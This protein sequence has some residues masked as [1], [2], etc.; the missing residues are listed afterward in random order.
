MG[1][2]PCVTPTDPEGQPG[3][4]SWIGCWWLGYVIA[5]CLVVSACLPMFFLFPKHIIPP[6]ERV[7]SSGVHTH[8]KDKDKE[9]ISLKD[10]IK[11]L[12]KYM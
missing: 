8:K 7:K 9:D 4:P 11:G 10:Q 2:Y 12:Y 3:D 5:A 6:E 1:F